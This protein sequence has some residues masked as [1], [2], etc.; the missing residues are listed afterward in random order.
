MQLSSLNKKSLIFVAVAGDEQKIFLVVFV[1]LRIFFKN[2][3]ISSGN[4]NGL[5]AW[6][7]TLDIIF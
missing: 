7:I 4:S 6:E 2:V 5:A 3:V 1:A